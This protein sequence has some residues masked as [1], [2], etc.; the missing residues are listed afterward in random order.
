MIYSFTQWYAIQYED[1]QTNTTHKRNYSHNHAVGH[2]KPGKI[3]TFFDSNYVHLKYSIL[4]QHFEIKIL[5]I[6]DNKAVVLERR[7]YQRCITA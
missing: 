7:K 6:F 3:F 5:V 1:E 2:W 4:F